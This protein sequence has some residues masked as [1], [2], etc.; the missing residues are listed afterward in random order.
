MKHSDPLKRATKPRPRGDTWTDDQF[1]DA[2]ESDL[3]DRTAAIPSAVVSALTCLLLAALLTSGKILEIAERQPLGSTRDRQV[4]MAEGLDRV[5]NFLSLNRPYDWIQDLRNAGEDAG[6]RIDT[7]DEVVEDLEESAAEQIEEDEGVSPVTEPDGSATT[8]TTTTAPA[9]PLRVVTSE[10]PLRLY[11][12]GDSQVT[13][14]GQALTTE[15]DDWALDVTVEDRISTSLARPDYFNWPAQI[16][17]VVEEQDPEAV[18]MF[19]GANDH[20]DMAADGVRLVVDTEEW[21]A[22]W[23]ERLDVMLD[24]LEAEHRRLFWVTQPPMRDARLDGGMELINQMVEEAFAD[25]PFVVMIDIYEMFGGEEGYRERV[26]YD[27]ET[28]RAR[29]DDGVHLTRDAQS[30]VADL[31]FAEMAEIWDFE[32]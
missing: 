26:T 27:D 3:R 5:A 11:A 14:L 6:E 4:S 15:S 19:L 23:R 31:V 32:D 20:Q 17:A 22:E 28:L 13:Y 9:G 10:D 25:R 1:R 21:Q 12:A 7:I 16:A 2:R 18:V 24:L 29:V 8:S 30:W